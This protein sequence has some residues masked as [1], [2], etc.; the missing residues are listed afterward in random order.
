[1]AHQARQSRV[2]RKALDDTL[3]VLGER[4]R[5]I[6]LA[7]LKSRDLYSSQNDFLDVSAISKCLGTFFGAASADLLINS[8]MLKVGE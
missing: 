3:L 7:E 6:I 2:N 1:M 5:N 8:A 4:G